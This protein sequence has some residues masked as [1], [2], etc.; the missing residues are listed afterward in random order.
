[1]TIK[2]VDQPASSVFRYLMEQ[3]GKNFVY[4]SE[5]LKD[6]RVSID[7]R[8]VSLKKA[9]TLIFDGK[10]IEY[11]IKGNNVVL[12]RARTKKPTRALTTRIPDP[13][14]NT[15]PDTSDIRTLDEVVIVSLTHIHISEHPTL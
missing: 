8:N 3:T 12:K 9:L 7:V 15:T 5:L 11:K 2:V 14:L 4:P 1:M 13:I 10:G 6:M